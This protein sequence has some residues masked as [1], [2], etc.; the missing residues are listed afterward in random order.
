MAV[1]L[2]GV[3]VPGGVVARNREHTG[4]RDGAQH[5]T[6]HR[7]APEQRG[8]RDQRQHRPDLRDRRRVRRRD[9]A[10]Q[11]ER[12]AGPVAVH[13]AVHLDDAEVEERVAVVEGL[14]QRP[15]RMAHEVVEIDAPP[16]DRTQCRKAANSAPVCTG[17]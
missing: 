2:E 10:D 12:T 11:R 8:Q 1:D 15:A 7:P 6:A 3:A 5:G 14:A 13:L 4:E 16:V 9:P 17:S